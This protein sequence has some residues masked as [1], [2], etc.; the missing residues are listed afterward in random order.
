MKFVSLILLMMIMCLCCGCTEPVFSLKNTYSFPRNK[1]LL[2]SSSAD[3]SFPA[4]MDTICNHFKELSIETKQVDYID[5]DCFVK[6][7]FSNS[8][9]INSEQNMQLSNSLVFI[10][11]IDFEKK[12]CSSWDPNTGAITA[13]DH[14]TT[15]S[16]GIFDYANKRY[17]WSAKSQIK[18]IISEDDKNFVLM[19][20]QLLSS[21]I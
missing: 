6:N 11:H 2:I 19:L 16:F 1:Q 15:I 3:D 17:L 13:A 10:F 7:V 18:K 20:D 9:E 14:S 12:G 5:N 8:L 4:V 21:I